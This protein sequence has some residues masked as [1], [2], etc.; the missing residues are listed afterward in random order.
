MADNYY[1]GRVHGAVAAGI[2]AMTRNRYAREQSQRQQESHDLNLQERE[3]SMRIRQQQ[4]QQNQM[5]LDQ[6]RQRTEADRAVR[7]AMRNAFSGSEGDQEDRMLAGMD[8]GWQKALDMGHADLAAQHYGQSN[9]LRG[10]LMARSLD[11]AERRYAMSGKQD[12]GGFIDSYN[13]YIPDGAKVTNW[14]RN[15]QDGSFT[16]DYSAPDGTTKQRVIA[17]DK[18]EGELT[19]LTNPQSV[20]QMM[21]ALAK[22]RAEKAIDTEA[23]VAE[24]EAKVHTA[25]P[26]ATLFSGRRGVIGTAPERQDI[27]KVL[28][29]ERVK[30]EDGSESIVTYRMGQDG[31]IEMHAPEG[32]GGGASAAGL[33]RRDV[34]EINRALNM[35]RPPQGT[36]Y[37]PQ[38]AEANA[39]AMIGDAALAQKIVANNRGRTDLP[40]QITGTA[41]VQI[42][43]DAR[44]GQARIVAAPSRSDPTKVQPVAVYQDGRVFYLGPAMTRQQAAAAGTTSDATPPQGRTGVP[45]S[46][47]E[48]RSGTLGDARV[49]RGAITDR[50]GATP[51]LDAQ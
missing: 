10:K 47:A 9:E 14:Q 18:I 20:R 12:I 7:E 36:V 28:R 51:Y 11:K 49:R 45:P 1:G 29:T 8:A 24:E 48:E 2:D 31:S 19:M 37:S 27:G 22:R 39:N 21:Q 32:S 41:A 16:L 42:A 13:R 3:Q 34:D 40:N 17:A 4:E 50:N 25:A 15:A 33:T 6:M 30:N 5:G 43:R 26:G 46:A 44:T 35:T 38:Q 23:K